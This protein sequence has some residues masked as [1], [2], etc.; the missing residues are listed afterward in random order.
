[1]NYEIIG[2]VHGH[3]DKLLDLLRALGYREKAGA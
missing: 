1:M 3:Q 2:D